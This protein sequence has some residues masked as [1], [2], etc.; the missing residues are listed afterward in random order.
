MLVEAL[1]ICGF[2]ISSPPAAYAKC[3]QGTELYAGQKWQEA[4]E[5]FLGAWA[6]RK[7]YDIAAN[8]GHAEHKLGKWRNAAEHFAFALR[9]WPFA[10]KPEPRELARQRFEEVRA[11]VGAVTIEVSVAGAEVAIDG[12]TVGVSPLPAEAYVEPGARRVEARLKGY[13]TASRAMQATA[14]GSK[15]VKLSLVPE[16]TETPG[17]GS[18]AWRL[19]LIIGGGVASA[20]G[21]GLGIGFT[22][23][24]NGKS[25][26]AAAMLEEL[27]RQQ[28]PSGV[29]VCAEPTGGRA[30]KCA[31]L[32]DTLGD[33]GTA[34]NVAIG[35]FIAG[36]ALALGT[37]GIGVLTILDRAPASHIQIAPVVGTASGGIIIIGLW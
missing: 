4:E 28:I 34:T 26:D 16:E 12:K 19:P 30:S 8:L 21:I 2:L 25:D 22:V 5:A 11:K 24:A 17:G 37:A 27:K 18:T 32:D 1:A 15:T 35:S 10:G 6:I 7:T 3:V 9:N 13:K 31:A 33:W 36:G 20:V 14:G 23:A 29:A